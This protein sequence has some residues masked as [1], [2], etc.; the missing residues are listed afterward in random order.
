VATVPPQ[1]KV[2]LRPEERKKQEEAQKRKE[3]A[4]E[5]EKA[6]KDYT[7]CILISLIVS[8]DNP[9]YANLGTVYCTYNY[10]QARYKADE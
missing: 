9:K 8:K 7:S 4:K 10:R 5:K 3:L 2:Y 6:Q 1:R